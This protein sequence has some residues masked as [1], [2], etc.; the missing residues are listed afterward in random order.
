[1]K[2]HNNLVQGSEEWLALREEYCTASEAPSIFGESK[3]KSRTALLNE[4]KGVKE[5]ISSQTQKIFDRGHETEDLARSLLEFETAETFEPIVA[6]IEIDGLKLLASLDGLSEDHKTIFEH[7]LWNKTLVENVLNEVLE[8]TYYWQLEHQLLVT[9]AE[10]VLF[11][12]SDGTSDNR[13]TM[14]YTSK[15]ERREK[16]IAGWHEFNKDL[17]NHEVKA[18]K[19]VAVAREQVSF[20]I[21][22]CH[23]EGSKVVSNLGDYIPKIKKLAD[24]QMSLILESDQDFADKEAFNKNVKEGR[25]KIKEKAADIEQQFESLAEF[26]GYVAEA[27]NILQKLQSHGEKQ[28]KKAKEVKKQSIINDASKELNN[29]LASLSEGING[30]QINNISI[31]F[32]AAM[33]G[34]RNFEKMEEAVNSALANAKI[35]A[36]EI[37][38]VIRKNLDSITELASSYKFLFSDHQSLILKDNDDLVNLIKARILEHEQ[39]EAERNRIEVERIEREAKEK[40]EREVK[41]KAEAEAQRIRNEE[42][43]KYEAEQA[44]ARKQEQ[45]KAMAEF[46]AE[47]SKPVINNQEREALQEAN[48]PL[49]GNNLKSDVFEQIESSS[50]EGLKH[51]AFEAHKLAEKKWY[52]YACELPVGEERTK[53]FDVYENIRLATRVN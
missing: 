31:D 50:I 28:V 19:E 48:S 53:A 26:N 46:E 40:A 5:A 10:R 36:N 33:K 18:K 35:E 49:F 14:Y 27:D 47:Q 41:A 4:K 22:E 37:A 38:Q 42:R 8:P 7:K 43:A 51:E 6:T 13:E 52:A 15:P 20:P 25:A 44:E 1:M 32:D 45:D 23:V 29:H 16:L 2:I 11:M 34:K 24:E 9:G 17:A 21:V 3:Y 39:A 30:V 12:V